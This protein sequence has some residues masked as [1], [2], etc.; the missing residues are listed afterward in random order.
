MDLRPTPDLIEE[1]CHRAPDATAV[2]FEGTH[3]TFSELDDRAARFAAR[4]RELGVGAETVVGVCLPRGID[5][6]VT[7]V[8]IWQAGGAYVP[9]DPDY[10]RERLRYMVA[11]ATPA[12]LVTDTTGR[13]GALLDDNEHRPELVCLDRD[14]GTVLAGARIDLRVRTAPDN[15]AYVIY[16]SGSTGRPKATMLD[17]RSVANYLAWTRDLL[18]VGAGD[19]VLLRTAISFDPSVWELFLPLTT[20]ARL[21]VPKQDGHRE[22]DYLSALIARERV[23]VAQF[24]PS[25][26]HLFL[27]EADPA[28]C[29]SLRWLVAGGEALPAALADRVAAALD[30]EFYNLYGPT[31]TTISST[32]ARCRG[33]ESPVPIGVAVPGNTLHVLDEHLRPV[34]PGTPGELHIGGV[35]VGRGYFRRP[36]LTAARFVPD[37]TVPGGRLYRTGDLVRERPDGQ[38]DYLGRLDNQIKVNGVRVE[39]GEI[40][41]VLTGHPGVAAAV[42]HQRDGRLVA[43]V[44]PGPGTPGPGARELREH[45]ADSLPAMVVPRY[46]V[47]L[48]RFPLNPAGKVDRAA[49]PAPGPERA[50]DHVAPSNDLERRLAGIWSAV[51]GA[52]GVGVTDH[53]LDVGGHSLAGIRVVTRIAR[54]LGVRL[55]FADLVRAGTVAGLA[56]LIS[57]R[58]RDA[59]DEPR[60]LPRDGRPLPL[61][62]AQEQLWFVEQV[63]DQAGT[64]NLA[65]ALHLSGP[66]DVDVL[67]EAVTGLLARHETLRTT[68]HAENGVPYARVH[69]PGAARMAVD[70]VAPDEVAAALAEETARPFDLATYPLVRARVLRVGADEH[71]LVVVVHHIVADGMSLDV[72]ARDLGSIYAGAELPVPAMQY[73]DFAAWQRERLTGVRLDAGLSYWKSTLD[74]AELVLDLP[75]DLVRPAVQDFHGGRVSFTVDGIL[76]ARLRELARAG[77][78]TLF[79]VLLAG[80]QALLARYTGRDDVLVGSPVSG[81][82]HVDFEPLAG[83]FVNT[84]VFR[85]SVSGDPSF[86]QLLD[87]VAETALGA[88]AHQDVPFERLVEALAPDRDLTRHP[89]VQAQFVVESDPAAAFAVPG[90]AARSVPV[91]VGGVKCDLRLAVTE[92]AG[93]L[94]GTLEFDR[95]VVD[96][97]WAETFVAHWLRLLDLVAAEPDR[98]VMRVPLTPAPVPRRVTPAVADP[99]EPVARQIAARPDRVAVRAAGTDVTYAELGARVDRLAT[100][101]V[102]AGAGPETLVAVHL[103]RDADLVVA[104]MAVWRA[105][106]GFVPLDPEHP[107]ARL[108][109][110][111]DDTRP[112]VLLTKKPLPGFAGPVVQASDRPVDRI[113]EFP[114]AEP[115]SLAYVVHTSGSTGAA[116]GIAGTRRGVANYLAD[117]RRR[118]Y[119]GPGDTVAAMTTVSFDASLRDLVFPLTVGARIALLTDGV[120]D[121]DT[122][123]DVLAAEPVSVVASVVPSVLRVLTGHLVRRRVTL[124]ALRTVLVSGEP[125]HAGDVLDLAVVAP[126]A[127]VVNMYG[128]SE[129]TMTTTAHEVRAPAVHRHVPV[130][131]P[132]DGTWVELLDDEMIPVGTGLP[133]HVYVGGAGLARGYHGNPTLTADRFVPHPTLPGQR[134]YRTGDRARHL[135]DGTLQYLGRSDDQLKVNGVRFD[136]ADVEAALR[137]HPTVGR[138][139][140]AV[141]GV[142][143]AYVVADPAVAAVAEPVVL[144]AFLAESLPHALVP[145]AYVPLTEL[146]TTPTGKLARRA[147]PAPPEPAMAGGRAPETEAERV[148]AAV[149]AQVLDVP[150][151]AADANYFALGGDSI[152]AIQIVARAASAG[153]H[154]TPRQFFAH[155]TIAELAAVATPVEAPVVIPPDWAARRAAILRRDPAAA[156]AY[157]LA[158]TQ[159]GMLFHVLA[160]PGSGLYVSQT[161]WPQEGLDPDTC[162]AAWA[163]LARRHPVLR[164]R[165]VLDDRQEPWQVVDR[166]ATPAADV[167]LGTAW[168]PDTHRKRLEELLLTDRIR[169]FDPFEAP[170][171]RLTMVDLADGDWVVA[172]T[173]HHLV[174]DGWSLVALVDEYLAVYDALRAGAPPPHDPAPSWSAHIAWLRAQDHERARPFWQRSLAGFREPTPLPSRA[175]GGSGHAQCERLLDLG[176]RLTG[177]TRTHRVTANT[178]LQAAWGLVLSRYAGTPDVVFGVTRSGRST[179]PDNTRMLGMFINTLPVRVTIPADGDLVTWLQDNQRHQAELPSDHTPLVRVHGWSEVPGNVPLFETILVVEN[180]PVRKSVRERL[181]PA[182][183]TA[184]SAKTWTNYPFTLVV[185]PGDRMRLEAVFDRGRYD[186][187]FV[188]HVLANFEAVLDNIITDTEEPQ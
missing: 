167:V 97:A 75:S 109:G 127:R 2:T 60:P 137:A 154:L 71:V 24:V 22:P 115:D 146:P 94:T 126:S 184:V 142:L 87:R 104:L 122:A 136:P 107:P 18:P 86:R 39:A 69:P 43:Y 140:V 37:P 123:V 11:D 41:A 141:H 35:A 29:A 98:P 8:A 19:A 156:D 121:L 54:Q 6:I 135:P 3:L 36:G 74:G 174:L 26:L 95:D 172:L 116:K 180:Y 92:H 15:L 28:S 160:E 52:D 155:Q 118:E 40:E 13:A 106:A 101:L 138:A 70:D 46:Y 90:L 81:R 152:R 171:V 159:E 162:T 45:L 25:L 149:W 82:D 129:T 64:Y 57:T 157:P 119:A 77:Q 164:T 176:D 186:D 170:L 96:Q 113:A 124:P 110:I 32:F 111:L 53:F 16:T 12:V 161:V 1:Q 72:L 183:A 93:G 85:T 31:E 76:C 9:L 99:W 148:L 147:L 44:V 80:Y 102:G 178:V 34:P 56:D 17:H 63:G 125:L 88:Y 173:S 58:G 169:G 61:S 50:E 23:T 179:E 51:L 175:S 187:R 7:L 62:F 10:P 68:F 130:G 143:V 48:P 139:A 151:P 112:G 132:I 20:G 83:L 91:P 165:F 89:I 30:V 150:A 128:P 145:S 117:M 38:L 47:T 158:P 59:A 185:T 133:G 21:V 33:G 42:V 163:E 66:L 78:A 131:R 181:A 14:R 134:L 144:R 182:G 153:L 100:R 27:D 84:V 177:F 73:A 166:H 103:G 4:L 65:L 188:A 67:R 105:G 79:M 49:L 120:A 168:P 108:A 55:T 5:L 114:R